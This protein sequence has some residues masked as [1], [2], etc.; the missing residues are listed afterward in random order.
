[1]PEQTSKIAWTS[2]MAMVLVHTVAVMPIQAC[3][4]GY[5]STPSVVVE[6][7]IDAL[8]AVDILVN[9]FSAYRDS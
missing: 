6:Y 9:F 1:M 2:V 4:A 7:V 8:L 5:E 3:F